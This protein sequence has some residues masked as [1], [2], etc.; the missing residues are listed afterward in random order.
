MPG[1]ELF[2]LLNPGD[3]LRRK[4]LLH[5]FRLVP[6]HHRQLCKTGLPGRLKWIM[7]HRLATDLV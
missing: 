2:G 1:A 5:L 3:V 6:D 4:G 7:Q